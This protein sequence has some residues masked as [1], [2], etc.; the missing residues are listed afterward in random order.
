MPYIRLKTDKRLVGFFLFLLSIALCQPP[1]SEAEMPA[2]QRAESGIMGDHTMMPG[3]WMFTYSH[4]FMN[5]AGNRDGNSNLSRAEVHEDFAVAPTSM[6]MRMNMFGLMYGVNKKLT[7]MGGVP[8]IRNSMDLQTRK[9]ARFSTRSAG[10]GDLLLRA[11]WKAYEKK[12][13]HKTSQAHLNIG[14]SLPTGSI[15]K[16]DETPM[17]RVRLPY[18]MQLGSGT[19]DPLLG[20]HYTELRGNW[21]WGA[22]TQALFRVGKNDEGYRLGHDYRFNLWLKRQLKPNLVAVTRLAGKAWRDISGRD[23]RLNPALVPTARAD[24][25]AGEQADLV[26]NLRWKS[27]SPQFGMNHFSVEAGVPVYQRLD[28]P[29][30]KSRYYSIVSWRRM[31]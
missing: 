17:G 21:G 24:L 16:R 13:G 10:L 3:K 25:R 2:R 4:Y 12:Q 23:K 14:A 30:L 5:M 27:D 15:D 19:I 28:G 8:H 7:L 1:Q 31:F 29:Q 18:P 26:F 11:V 6:S 20:V 22:H 9:G